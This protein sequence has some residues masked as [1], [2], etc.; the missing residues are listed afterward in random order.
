MAITRKD[1]SEFTD[2][3]DAFCR[4]FGYSRDEVIGKTSRALN[5]FVND[6]N[7]LF[8]REKLIA[9]GRIQNRELVMRKKDGSLIHGLF[10]G[11]M[12][13]SQGEEHF[14]TVLI[15][16]TE[17]SELR[18]E[19]T[20]EQK[21]LENVIEGTRLG[22][23]EWNIRTGETVFN[24]RWAEMIGY[25]LEELSPVSIK[26]WSLLSHPD[27]LAESDRL[28]EEHF[29]GT[30]EF[31]EFEGRM[32]HKDGRWIWVYDRGKV[33]ERDSEGCPVKMYG[34]H[35][36]ITE[37]KKMQEKITE[38]AINDTHGHIAGD[39]VLKEFANL[40]ASMV[41][42]YDLA[43]RFGGEEFIIVSPES[44]S[45]QIARMTERILGKVRDTVFAT[46]TDK[47]RFT[48]SA[49]I[50][51][52]TEVPGN[53]PIIAELLALADKRFYQAK[54]EGRDRCKWN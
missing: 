34:T 19:L 13:N 6:D 26:T 31:Y 35:A 1:T 10:S 42:T 23:W 46:E 44:E 49:G 25:T 16:V 2:I 48:F 52:S 11:D 21:R 41:R 45:A 18:A 9:G 39:I 12:I 15:D 54:A 8:T 43:G 30:S 27:D 50:A 7:W 14:L 28:L 33:I 22:T 47:I 3:N 38:L 17:E 36:D 5:L 51:C 53:P 4:T 32:K 24:E 29:S 20:T 37:Q 40:V